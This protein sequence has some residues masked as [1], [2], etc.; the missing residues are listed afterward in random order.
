[1]K[2]LKEQEDSEGIII[3]NR[4]RERKTALR[5]SD[6]NQR[7]KSKGSKR[8]KSSRDIKD[9]NNE[10]LA[11]QQKS[12]INKAAINEGNKDEPIKGN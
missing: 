4:S 3:V 10:S 8:T 12:I 11:V 1:V 7:K 5:S 6:N 9:T 2:E